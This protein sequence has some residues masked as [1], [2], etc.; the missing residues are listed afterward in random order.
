MRY[1]IVYLSTFI[2]LFSSFIFDTHAQIT[3]GAEENEIYIST[4]WYIDYNDDIHYAI[5]H[6]TDNGENITLKYE[7]IEVTPHLA[8]C[9]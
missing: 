9:R 5:F 7:N 4:D 2:F 1:K 3:R 8:R 6:S